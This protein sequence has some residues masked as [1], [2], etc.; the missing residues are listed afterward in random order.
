MQDVNLG[1]I[2]LKIPTFI[3]KNDPEA[4]IEWLEKVESIYDVHNYSDKIRRSS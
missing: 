2:K 3:R 4:F 1:S